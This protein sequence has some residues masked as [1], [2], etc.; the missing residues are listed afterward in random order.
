[1]KSILEF[2]LP[3]DKDDFD[4]AVKAPNYYNALWDLSNKIRGLDKYEDKESITIDEL[5]K[6]FYDTLEDN[7]IQL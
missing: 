6:L 4:M 1:M 2:N 3:E 5:R 7:D